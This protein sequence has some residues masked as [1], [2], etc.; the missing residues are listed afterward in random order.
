MGSFDVKSL[1]TDVPVDF[2]S[3]IKL[4]KIFSHDIQ[5]INGLNKQQLKRLLHWA[6]KGTVF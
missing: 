6:T 3:N 1:F 4:D 2:T 5:S